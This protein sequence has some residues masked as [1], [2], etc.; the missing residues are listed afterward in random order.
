MTRTFYDIHLN[1]WKKWARRNWRKEC[2]LGFNKKNED[3]EDKIKDFIHGLDCE[4]CFPK[5]R[6]TLRALHYEMGC[7]NVFKI[8]A[9]RDGSLLGSLLFFVI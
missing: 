1:E 8:C 3:E 7:E 2:K 5:K 9:L 6:A 4:N